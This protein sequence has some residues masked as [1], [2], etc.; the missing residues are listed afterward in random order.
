VE[1]ESDDSVSSLS[2]PSRTKPKRARK[3]KPAAKPKKQDG[4][5]LSVMAKAFRGATVI[6]L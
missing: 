4:D 6:S 2:S 3:A 1:A 5:S